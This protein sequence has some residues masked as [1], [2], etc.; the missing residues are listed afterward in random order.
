MKKNLKFL[1]IV[2]SFIVFGYVVIINVLSNDFFGRIDLTQNKIYSIS[3]VSKNKLRNL[4]DLITLELYFSDNLPQNL[5]KV[6]KDI[7]DLTDEFKIY[8]GRNIRIV[9][10]DPLKKQ[11]DKDD[12]I[13]LNI[14]AIRVQSIEKDKVQFVDGYMGIAIRYAGKSESIPLVQATDNFEY[15][16]I[17]RIIRLSAQKLPIVGIVKTD[18]A[19]YLDP[20][21][22]DF[23]VMEIPEDITHQRYKPI[24]Q[25]LMPTYNLQ[26]IN[27]GRDTIIDPAIST[28]IIPGEDEAS[29]FVNP[30]AI[31]AIDQYLM[32]GG[33]VIVL[34][35]K[36]AIN[37]Q[38][39]TNA[40]V[41]NTFLYKMLE[42]WGVVVKPE[43]LID[44]SCGQIRVPRQVG[45]AIMNVPTD[46]PLMVRVAEDGFNRTV[47]PLASMT[48][49]IFPWASPL[50]I[51]ENLDTA[52]IAD[53]L[54][55]SSQYSTIRIP[56]FRIDPNQNW[57]FF[58]EKAAEN[59][60]L[61]R[62]P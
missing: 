60:T 26:Y 6:Q 7:K 14:P 11:S 10:K 57:E 44:A 3:N 31:C 30:N 25:A 1:T 27:F 34:A 38:K 13:A 15:E 58:F 55:M 8:A 54:I 39:S 37:L 16:I 43:M 29:Y 2:F 59:G 51:S 20:R 49:V 56:P 17:Q 32:R 28:I 62:Y 45:P 35:Q 19:A 46:Y 9:W 21:L 61:K 50:E 53:T 36:F 23:Y 22:A 4:N 42:E 40:S 41:S 33:N 48:Q 24:F 52:T 5:K 18:T 47:S 12:A